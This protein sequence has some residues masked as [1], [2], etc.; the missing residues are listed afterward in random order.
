MFVYES[1][2]VKVKV[3]VKVTAA[4]KVENSYF[5]SVKL[6]SLT[7]PVLQYRAMKFARMHRGVLSY[8]GSN[9]VTAIFVTREPVI[10]SGQ[11][12]LGSCNSS[13]PLRD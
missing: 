7:T 5:S 3:K 10:T 2:Q 12:E 11:L 4:T 1:H 9:G 6:R 13:F 8:G